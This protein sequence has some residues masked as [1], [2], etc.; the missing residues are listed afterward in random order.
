MIT[1]IGM[2]H[3]QKDGDQITAH[4]AM[5]VFSACR[6]L[7]AMKLISP[8]SLDRLVFSGANRTWQSALVAKA[9][10]GFMVP[11]LEKN[12][13]FH[14]EL[15]FNEAYGNEKN[16]MAT[17]LSEKK[18][19]KESGCTVA[20]AL[21]IGHGAKI[22]RRYIINAIINLAKDMIPRR[23]K[24]ALVLTHSP[25]VEL[26]VPMDIAKTIP[27]HISEADSVIYK[28]KFGK[29]ISAELIKAPAI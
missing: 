26:A 27:Y 24:T 18:E 4:G 7:V 21:E 6:Q 19:I 14:Y 23:H 8:F 29:I 5:Q 16:P 17:F 12:N 1:I 28:I 2:R 22:S 10:I 9:A 20:R 13:E 25:L 11:P 15:P 3:P